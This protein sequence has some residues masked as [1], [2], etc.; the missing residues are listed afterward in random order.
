[1]IC[2]GRITAAASFH[3]EPAIDFRT[4]YVKIDYSIL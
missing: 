3:C 4:E 2:T 1:M